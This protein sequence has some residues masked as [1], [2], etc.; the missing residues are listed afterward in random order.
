MKQ[1]I[2]CVPNFSEGIDTIVNF[3][4]LYYMNNPLSTGYNFQLVIL[5]VAI[6]I[7]GFIYSFRPSRTGKFYPKPPKWVG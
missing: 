2:E 7:L 5:S 1:L 3:F 4:Q 6:A